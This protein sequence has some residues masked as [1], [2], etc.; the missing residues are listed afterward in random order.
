[1]VVFDEAQQA[2]M[3]FTWTKNQDWASFLAYLQHDNVKTITGGVETVLSLCL[4]ITADLM[5][6]HCCYVIWSSSKWIA[7]PFI[8]VISSLAIC[9]IVA[10]AFGI[11]GVSN[12]TDP[13]KRQLFLQGNTI[14]T[15][16]WLANMGV[17]FI[18]TLLTAG[19]IWWIT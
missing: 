4:V 14:D 18:L 3:F 12:I 9:E 11:I 10:S 13:A 19:C 8:F 7:F 2:T 6:L 16:F 17:N 5:L 1:M 15:A